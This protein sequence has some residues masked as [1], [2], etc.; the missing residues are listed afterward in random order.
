[1][2]TP[3]KINQNCLILYTHFLTEM[4]NSLGSFWLRVM[5]YWN[6]GYLLNNWTN[7]ER[8]L[9][10]CVIIYK[11]L[12]HAIF[13]HC[14]LPFL[15]VVFAICRATLVIHF[16]KEMIL[17][18]SILNNNNG[19]FPRKLGLFIWSIFLRDKLYF[20]LLRHCTTAREAS[21][22]KHCCHYVCLCVWDMVQ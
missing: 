2:L 18:L 16:C 1:M 7:K 3:K 14:T 19:I 5:K 21:M 12:S 4:A 15:T 11:L 13:L 22:I 8:R 9:V 10:I 17:K 6:W 20:Q